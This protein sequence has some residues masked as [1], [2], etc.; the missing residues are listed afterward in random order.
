MRTAVP[1][2]AGFLAA[3]SAAP[4]PR[5]RPAA[6]REV[7]FA[8]SNLEESWLLQGRFEG[9][10]RVGPRRVE[11][12]VP[13][14]TLR[15]PD[16]ADVRPGGLAA[17]LATSTG[18][19][20]FVAVQSREVPIGRVLPP[21]SDSVADTLRFTIRLP[22]KLVLEKHWLVF[23]LGAASRRE[24]SRRWVKGWSYAHSPRFLFRER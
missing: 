13:R 20:W 16:S 3:C 23:S 12:V 22:P 14:A 15:V 21:G 18:S 10:A 17:G 9:M 1:F 5:A 2:L 19:G 24:G 4:P 11:V 8:V 6:V 7:P